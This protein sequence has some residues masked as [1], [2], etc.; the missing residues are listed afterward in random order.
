MNDKEKS[1]KMRNSSS[2]FS[3]CLK[4]CQL[5]ALTT[6][7]TADQAEV[8]RHQLITTTHDDQA[9]DVKHN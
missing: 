4:L 1:N 6:G 8:V 7:N 3:G 9:E 2:I 5:T